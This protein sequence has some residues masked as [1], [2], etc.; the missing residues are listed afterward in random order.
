MCIE[1]YIVYYVKL[2]IP[3][4]STIN[5]NYTYV[6]DGHNIVV[7]VQDGKRSGTGSIIH[8]KVII[9][10]MTTNASQMLCRI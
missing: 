7:W 1:W 10:L 3:Q 9:L 8:L 2:T 5:D 4:A 6:N